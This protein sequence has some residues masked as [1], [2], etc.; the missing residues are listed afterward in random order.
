MDRNQW[1]QIGLGV[2][3]GYLLWKYVLEGRVATGSALAGPIRM[4]PKGSKYTSP[5]SRTP[6]S[7]ATHRCVFGRGP[8]CRFPVGDAYHER[9]ALQYVQAGRCSPGEC[10]EVVRY[11]A[12]KAR[13]PEVRRRAKQERGV[14]LQSAYRSKRKRR[15]TRARK[16]A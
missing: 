13:D 16:A 7:K 15:R 9:K 14:I 4:N 5:V 12:K 11:L 1:L 10:E 8:T 6:R 3:G 2:A